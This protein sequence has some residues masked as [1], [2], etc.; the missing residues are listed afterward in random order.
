MSNN[1]YFF[2]W[3]SSRSVAVHTSVGEIVVARFYSWERDRTLVHQELR[4]SLELYGLKLDEENA[5][6]TVFE[7][8]QKVLA[9]NFIEGWVVSTQAKGYNVIAVPHQRRKLPESA[10]FFVP[11]DSVQPLP[12]SFEVK[13]TYFKEAGK[14]Y[15][16]AE[17]VTYCKHLWQMW[18]EIRGMM[19][20][21]TLPGLQSG[22]SNYIVQVDVPEHPFNH[23]A[24]LRPIE[25]E[26]D[27]TV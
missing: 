26:K 10:Y 11:F 13:L 16:H 7:I 22:H 9:F 24:L 8:G 20:S 17:Y 15:A 4:K 6:S 12:T 14:Y 27:D 5:L 2:R 23:P 1:S 3:E 18:E 21:R 25:N 19:T